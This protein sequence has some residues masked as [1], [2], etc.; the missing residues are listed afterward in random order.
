MSV[1]DISI[2]VIYLMT[3]LWIG[4]KASRRATTLQDHISTTQGLSAPVIIATLL[5]TIIGGGHTTGQAGKIYNIGLIYVLS[6]MGMAIS[7][8]ISAKWIMPHFEKFKG[9]TSIGDI[10]GTLYG[11]KVRLIVGIV[12]F[13]KCFGSIGGQL[14]A[15]AYLLEALLGLPIKFGILI[16]GGIVIGYSAYGG[17]KAVTATDIFQFV[18][19]IIVIP[20]ISTV[21]LSKVGGIPELIRQVPAERLSI[22]D[23][24]EIIKHFALFIMFS[25]P[26]LAPHVVHKYLLADGNIGSLRKAVY[27]AAILEWPLLII[28]TIISF[29]ALIHAPGL[30][31]DDVISYTIT[32]ILPTP[33]KGLAI[34]GMLAVIMST[35]DS[36]LN[37]TTV[38][39]L[40]DI[41]PV[42]RSKRITEKQKVYYM[43]FT[44]LLLGILSILVAFTMKSIIDII[45]YF[46]SFYMA[47]ITVPLL[48]GILKAKVSS[49]AFH[50][51]G[52]ISLSTVFLLDLILGAEFHYVN[53]LIGMLLGFFTIMIVQIKKDYEALSNYNPKKLVIKKYLKLVSLYTILAQK[54]RIKN[55]TND[56][57]SFSRERVK[58]YGAE[59]TLL[60]IFGCVNYI[61]PYFVFNSS[62]IQGSGVVII[63]RIISGISCL[64]LLVKDY[65]PAK[66]H[67]YLPLYWHIVLLISLPMN[68]TFFFFLEKGSIEWLLNMSLAVFMLSLLIDWLS[69][70]ILAVVGSGLGCILAFYTIGH[71]SIYITQDRLFLV[72]YMITFSALIGFLFGRN[73][74][75]SHN[76]KLASLKTLAGAIAHEIVTPLSS[77]SIYAEQIKCEQ[78][79][80]IKENII[81]SVNRSKS[82]ISTILM[83]IRD[84]IP[85][86]SLVACSITECLM[87]ALMK[88][89]FVEGERNFIEV[90]VL[91]DFIINTDKIYFVQIFTN[92][93]KNSLYYVKYKSNPKVVVSINE[94]INH[95]KITFYD[96]GMG[97]DQ[98]ILIHV[99]KPFFSKRAGGAGIGLTF[100]KM[101]VEGLGG[102]I[103][104]K[105]VKGEFTEFTIEFN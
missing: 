75:L 3:T 35:A 60:A 96:N 65:W 53:I 102:H 6:S 12:G 62:K 71:D 24:V 85:K 68:T 45:I 56:I 78:N 36:I 88:Y 98:E 7:H 30:K 72:L 58:H 31:G 8:I 41:L 20:T 57:V 27:T 15:M 101:I 44:T 59:Y 67:K 86:N 63:L 51:N 82:I 39:V 99:F 9:L 91:K 10:M 1:V 83:N 89:P 95:K 38:L 33:I 100:C 61:M 54:L 49:L 105:S 47:V 70:I 103:M 87:E 81:F 66:W 43:V 46:G 79:K 69:F 22:P 104:C 18:I 48:V 74:E 2:V 5:A 64:L 40:Q 37:T 52:V 76:Q 13:I 34:A 19:L 16:S 17:V 42:I 93:I 23:T 32:E 73:N 97:I 25:I 77:I 14:L 11:E 55:F 4:I 94:M 29:T 84:D 21:C 28:I 90:R 80:A 92:L 50:L 26:Y